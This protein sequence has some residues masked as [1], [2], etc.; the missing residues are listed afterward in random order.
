MTYEQIFD[1]CQRI[2]NIDNQQDRANELFKLLDKIGN[3]KKYIPVLNHLIREIGIYPYINI[4]T[5]IFNDKLVCECF[6][7]NVGE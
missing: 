3:K 6:K 7:T 2:F 5:A 4:D 1:E